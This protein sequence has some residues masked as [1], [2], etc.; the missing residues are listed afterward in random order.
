MGAKCVL[1]TACP[2]VQLPCDGSLLARSSHFRH[3][4]NRFRRKIERA[5]VSFTW[6]P[7]EG[8]TMD[9]FDV[10]F[11]LHESRRTLKGGSSS[12][13]RGLQFDLHRRL[14]SRSG[15]ARG[16]AMVL[17]VCGGQP[18]G[19]LYGFVWSE[20]FY[21]YQIGW[22]AAWARQG[23]GKVLVGES[24]RLAGLNGIRCFDFLRGSETYKYRFDA[25]DRV[26]ETWLLPRGIGG[27]LVSR[28]YQAVRLKRG[29]GEAQEQ[30]Q[31]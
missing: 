16:P 11:S 23:L 31:G 10:F 27:W 5:M 2:R 19:A 18:V 14:I 8:M 30:L 15:P 6:T 20:T 26:D 1:T 28:K 17:A 4:F 25:A 21:F 12:F 9:A 13:R 7:P 24:M 3:E 22:D 29:R